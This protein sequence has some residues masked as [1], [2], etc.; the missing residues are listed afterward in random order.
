[1][2]G[3]LNYIFSITAVITVSLSNVS[4]NA[5]CHPMISTHLNF[6]FTKEYINVKSDVMYFQL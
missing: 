3:F 1:M 6:L 5:H 4:V 2:L